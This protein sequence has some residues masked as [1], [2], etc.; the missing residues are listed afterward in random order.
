MNLRQI[1]AFRTVMLAGSV[2]AAAGSLHLTQPTISKLIAQLERQTKLRLFD[3]VR[4]RLVPRREAHSLL[5]DVDKVLRA[6]EEVGRSAR[7]LARANTGHIRIGAHPSLGTGFLPKA[8]ASFIKSRPEVRVTLNVRES[9]YVKEWVA[10]QI[11]DI[12]FVSDDSPDVVGT[13]PVRF[14]ERPGAICV[15]PKGHPLAK[16]K[17]LKPKHFA[18]ERI[19]SIGRDP[20]FRALIERCFVEAGVD[21][22]IAAETNNFA[23][24]C[25]LVAEG[26]GITVVD[27]YS[28]LAFHGYG[29]VA[30]RAFVPEIKFVVNVIRQAGQ[31]L[32]LI[33]EQFLVH[34]I[35]RKKAMDA[36][37]REILTEGTT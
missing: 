13:T 34:V 25:S 10:G 32:P 8:V 7:H 35:E 22:D 31:P 11:S 27:P 21:R 6:L 18:G 30:L 2:T 23:T 33:V 9:S 24:A 14:Q 37:L 17:S 1:E 16:R 36:R 15:I 4:G 28:A 12:G 19:V 29:G 20:N 26:A 3:R 5:Q